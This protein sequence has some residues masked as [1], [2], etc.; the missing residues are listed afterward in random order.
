MKSTLRTSLLSSLAAIL[1]LAAAGSVNA[2]FDGWKV[3]S[4]TTDD[5]GALTIIERSVDGRTRTTTRRFMRLKPTAVE[6]ENIETKDATGNKTGMVYSR[7]N[8]DG[9]QIAW[10]D[11]SYDKA[12]YTF[13]G[14]RWYYEEENGRIIEPRINEKFNE[15]TKRWERVHRYQG[16]FRNKFGH[17]YGIRIDGDQ[18]KI[19]TAKQVGDS[20]KFV[21]A[22]DAS[23]NFRP[24]KTKLNA[25]GMETTL[26]T[27]CGDVET[28][29]ASAAID[30]PAMLVFGDNDWTF[31]IV[32]R[33]VDCVDGKPQVGSAWV[34]LDGIPFLADKFFR[35]SDSPPDE[36]K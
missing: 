19:A 20:G 25:R 17:I 31:E 8:F 4:S 3:L 18:I 36:E 30:K 12:G 23:G 7:W 34:K 24:S 9:R 13:K 14:E 16:V 28:G 6:S 29:P 32:S 2:Q 11:E 35:I 26:W 21:W 15:R 33:D 5:T 10:G 27:A 1:L 22:P